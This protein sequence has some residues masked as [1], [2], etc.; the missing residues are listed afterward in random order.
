MAPLFSFLSFVW[1]RVIIPFT[2]AH[3]SKPLTHKSG[4]CGSPEVW[5][6]GSV[7]SGSG[8]HALI[9]FI[10]TWP[11]N[12]II[13]SSCTSV[14]CVV[15]SSLSRKVPTACGSAVPPV[16]TYTIFSSGMCP[17]PISRPRPWMMS[18]EARMRGVMWIRRLRDAP[19]VDLIRRISCRF[20]FDRRMSR[21]LYFTNVFVVKGSGMI[22][23]V[24]LNM[25]IV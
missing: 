10:L 13:D 25:F 12:K 21:Q 4:K 8:F 5:K 18:S 14:L 2:V 6:C 23:N 19:I 1:N 17:T 11:G 24:A 22:S 20:R 16:R 9:I 15:I 3:T 7:L